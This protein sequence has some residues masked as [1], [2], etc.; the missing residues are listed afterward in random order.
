[1]AS[2]G[3]PRSSTVILH[4]STI[5]EDR[6]GVPDA[7][8]LH[9]AHDAEQ[10]FAPRFISY[11][12]RSA[13]WGGDCASLAGHGWMP[14]GALR[15]R[16]ARAATARPVDVAIH[17]DGWG[18]DWFAPL[19]G[20]RRRIVYLHTERA[21]SD[22]LI[23][24]YAPWVDGFLSVSRSYADRVRRVLPE[25]P[26]ERVSVPPY[27]MKIPAWVAGSPPAN[28]AGGPWRL[29]YAGRVITGQKRLDR[30]PVLL[31]ELDRRGLD[32]VFEVAGDGPDLAPLRQRLAGHPRVR[33]PGWLRGEAYW[34]TVAGWA[35]MVLLSD[36]E[37]FSRAGMEAM[38]CGVPVVHPNF[39]PAA[40]ELLGP[41]A[42]AG[43]YPVGDMGAAADR[44]A[45]L[46]ALSLPERRALG[47]AC[48]AHLARHTK[49]NYYTVYGDF[50]ARIAAA[51]ALAR[52]P[53]RPPVWH[54]GMLLG[55]YT[56]LFPRWF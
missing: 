23:R 18:L 9:H 11:F 44:I 56:R 52:P 29:G 1:M 38:T 21:H 7:L 17:H 33:F 10:G 8:A 47:R 40:A 54:D 39:S 34:R 46:A 51:P 22:E 6:G 4:C 24:A 12:D 50:V 20:A 45:G 27:F 49:E 43:L 26:A 19:D 14:V 3:A 55:L 30:L 41:A 5:R 35:A 36:Y 37:G 28:P 32:Y 42:P 13:D 2:P 25:F 15:R 48:R 16:F 31:A 53:R